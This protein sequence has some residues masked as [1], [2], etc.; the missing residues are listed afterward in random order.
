MLKPISFCYIA[1]EQLSPVFLLFFSIT[2]QTS[3]FICVISR[4]AC[5]TGTEDYLWHALQICASS[6]SSS[7]WLTVAR[8]PVSVTTECVYV[9]ICVVGCSTKARQ[10]LLA[11]AWHAPVM[12]STSFSGGDSVVTGSV[13]F[14]HWWGWHI[15]PSWRWC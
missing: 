6:S 5:L 13:H 11:T 8:S 14:R 10:A 12:R 4:P 3:T 9:W 1:C 7:V 15:H 2:V